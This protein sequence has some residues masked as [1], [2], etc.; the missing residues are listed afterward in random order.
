MAPDV[1]APVEQPAADLVAQVV[2]YCAAS[3]QLG[4]ALG[5][6]IRATP[7]SGGFINGEG[8]QRGWEGR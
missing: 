1:A 2:A 7:I 4:P 6:G 3:A 8:R 5:A